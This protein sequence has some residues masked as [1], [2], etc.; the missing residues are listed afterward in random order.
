MD[1]VKKKNLLIIVMLV[2]LVCMS[3]TFALF[4]QR[5]EINGSAKVAS[6]NVK[7]S[8]I[9]VKA[10]S[11]SAEEGS[12]SNNGTIATISPVFYSVGDSVTYTVTVENKGSVDAKLDS[13]ETIVTNDEGVESSNIKYEYA[14]VKTGDVL[15]AGATNQ[16]TVTISYIDV[17]G[18]N[19]A[20]VGVLDKNYT[21]NGIFNYIQES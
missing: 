8:N 7:I 21:L 2:A 10:S 18:D 14:G 19:N 16:F 9:E 17:N 12:V 3:V 11:G 15:E 20:K 1:A 4:S 13:I 6:W 5:L